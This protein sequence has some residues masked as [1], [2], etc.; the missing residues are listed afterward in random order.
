MSFTGTLNAILPRGR[1]GLGLSALLALVVVGCAGGDT[2]ADSAATES[3]DPAMAAGAPLRIGYSDW[4][5]WVPWEI[6]LEKG[7]F[8]ANGVE[9]ELVW[10]DYVP[11]MDGFAAGAL[12]AVAMT[13]GDALVT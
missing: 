12:D 2:S 13:N 9:V 7:F 4:P 11:S 8:E 3:G 10:M 1:C 6:A 5:G